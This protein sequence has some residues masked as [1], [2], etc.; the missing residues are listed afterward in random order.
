MSNFFI[1]TSALTGATR[2]AVHT[3]QVE[4]VAKQKEI[5]TGKL[6]DVG[7]EIGYR[8]SEL[9]GLRNALE[10]TTAIKGSNEIAATRLKASQAALGDMDKLAGEL[11]NG[12][13]AAATS[14]PATS[15][16]EAQARSL[17]RSYTSVLNVEVAGD[18]VFGGLNVDTPPLSDYFEPGGSAARSKLQSAFQSAFGVSS[19]DPA[20]SSIE[21]DEIAS[22][23]DGQLRAMFEDPAWSANW[24]KA[25]ADTPVTRVSFGETQEVG[26]SANEAPFRQLAMALVMI[27]D[28]GGTNLKETTRDVV[29]A[30]ATELAGSAVPGIASVRS[31]LGLSQERV[32]AANERLSLQAD[33]ITKRRSEIEDVDPYSTAVKLNELKQRLEAS[34]ATTAQIQRLSLLDYLR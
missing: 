7:L 30:K 2:A 24:S 18:H 8:S 9:V 11:L 32:S 16:L 28:L 3:A 19:T 22:F 21:P 33:L 13:L 29:I 10:L 31:R 23:I 25:S 34:Y 20:V 5:A 6:A 14:S 15:P 26:A 1:S 27:S 4:L 12:L 17:L